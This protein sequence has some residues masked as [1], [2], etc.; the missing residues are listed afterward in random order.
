VGFSQESHK[1]GLCHTKIFIQYFCTCTQVP[2]EIGTYTQVCRRDNCVYLKKHVDLGHTMKQTFPGLSAV[3]FLSV[4]HYPYY[5]SPDFSIIKS[6]SVLV[7][8]RGFFQGYLPKNIG[9]Y[10][11]MIWFPVFLPLSLFELNISTMYFCFITRDA[12]MPHFFII[13]R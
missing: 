1:K 13:C 9:V 3:V 5:G 2:V 10:V 4:G 7:F 12:C 6:F 8:P 11:C